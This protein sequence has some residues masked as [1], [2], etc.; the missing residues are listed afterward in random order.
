M[1]SSTLFTR[2]QEARHGVPGALE[3]FLTQ[4]AE[5]LENWCR[6]WQASLLVR[7]HLVEDVVQEALFHVWQ[8]VRTCRAATTPELVAWLQAIGRHAAIDTLRL[9]HP[10]HRASIRI[11]SLDLRIESVGGLIADDEEV[12]PTASVLAAEVLAMLDRTSDA[13][14]RELLWLRLVGNESWSAIG[15]ALG[16][17][18]TAARRRYQRAMRRARAYLTAIASGDGSTCAAR[19]VHRR[20]D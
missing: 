12:D 2:F 7:M 11:V 15:M 10:E 1:T 18:W 3:A 6:N 17:S 8:H 14:L 20:L 4:T 13:R 9:N 19:I 5:V 16:I